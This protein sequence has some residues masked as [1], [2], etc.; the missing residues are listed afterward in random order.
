[1]RSCVVVASTRRE[2][3][4]RGDRADP[5]EAEATQRLASRDQ[6]VGVILADLFDQIPVER[7]H[8]SPPG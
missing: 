2:K 5:E 4:S 6:S 3:R 7:S 1:L 8:G